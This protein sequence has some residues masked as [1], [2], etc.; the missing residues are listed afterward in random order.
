[1][2]FGAPVTL[3]VRSSNWI[4]NTQRSAETLGRGESK[5]RGVQQIKRGILPGP[6]R[7][8]REGWEGTL[9]RGCPSGGE[10]QAEPEQAAEA[11]GPAFLQPDASPSLLTCC[12]GL[13]RHPVPCGTGLLALSALGRVLGMWWDGSGVQ[14]TWVPI[15]ACHLLPL[16]RL[17]QAPAV[18]WSQLPLLCNEDH[19]TSC[20]RGQWPG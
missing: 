9:A 8:Q 2:G 4:P 1:M 17:G 19:T 3:S 5:G 10:G 18:L 15:L 6:Q 14:W 16:V 20:H 7:L 13:V 11:E 12:L